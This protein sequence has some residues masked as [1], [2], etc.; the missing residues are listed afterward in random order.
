MRPKHE[1]T[2]RLLVAIA[3]FRGIYKRVAA[4]VGKHESF[5]SHVLRGNE[6]LRR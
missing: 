3:M 2:T 6:N 1:D 5:V 4:K